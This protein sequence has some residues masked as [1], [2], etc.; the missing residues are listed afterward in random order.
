M[1]THNPGED[2]YKKLKA[3]NDHDLAKAEVTLEGGP[4]DGKT[5]QIPNGVMSLN[6][7]ID[8]VTGGNA[9]KYLRSGRDTSVFVYYE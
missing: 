5:L 7:D 4:G 2:L 1:T 8:G 9:A 3:E 6:L